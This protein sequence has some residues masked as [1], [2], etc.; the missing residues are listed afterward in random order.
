MK[1]VIAMVLCTISLSLSAQNTTKSN[2]WMKNTKMYM[3]KTAGVSFQE[4]DGLNNRI[5][6]FPQY[7]TLKGHM[8]TVSLGSMNVMKNFITQMNVTAGSSLTGNPDERSSAIRTLA[9]S[10]DLGYDLIPSSRIMLYPTAGIGLEK[11]HA[12]FYKDVNAVDFDDVAN[13]PSLQNSIR[14]VKFTNYFTTYRFGL[15]LAFASP[16]GNHSVGLQGTYSGSFKTNKPWKSAENQSLNGAPTDE[17][18][19]ISVGVVFTGNMMGWGR[20]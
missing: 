12:V 15:G 8:F 1:S 20:K 5:S 13:S 17:L 14:S 4:F 7:K 6:G 18:N 11:Y 16:D 10:F 2:P 19:R 3:T 9:G